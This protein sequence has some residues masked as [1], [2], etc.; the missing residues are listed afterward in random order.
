MYVCMY[1]K[2]HKDLKQKKAQQ[3]TTEQAEDFGL[4]KVEIV[5][6]CRSSYNLKNVQKKI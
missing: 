4:R 6:V 2:K 3:K 1:F 5:Q